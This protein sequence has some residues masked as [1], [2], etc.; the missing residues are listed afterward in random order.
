[1]QSN[2]LTSRLNPKN[3]GV[4][5]YSNA[6][7][8][9]SAYA[10]AKQAGEKEFMW[11]GKRFST[12]SDMTPEQQMKVYGIT[13]KQRITN[14]STYR[15]NLYDL[16]T[17]EGYNIPLLNVVDRA[18]GKNEKV[19]FSNEPNSAA[20]KEQ[21]ALRL[22]LGLPQ[23]ANTFKPSKYK[24]DAFELNNYLELLPN[25]MP[26]DEEINFYGKPLSQED[27]YKAKGT[28]K[29][30]KVAN[31][32]SG[33]TLKPLEDFV[34]GKHTVK[35]GKDE[36]GE[37][38]EY[39]DE[40]DFD[41][42]K[43]NLLKKK[44]PL[45]NKKLDIN[46]PLGDISDKFNKPYSIYGRK[47]YKDYGDG[48]KKTMYYSDKELSELDI[49]KKNFD[50]L[51]LQKELNNRGYDLPKSTISKNKFDGILGKETIDALT[52][53]QNKNSRSSQLSLQYQL[54]RRKRLR[55]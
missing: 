3:W 48:I 18:L 1:M 12:K 40:F 55:K 6:G 9:N 31:N 47:Y 11:N 7:N 44:I 10:S 23:K 41:T 33:N 17:V 53:W 43:L 27:F 35:K 46:I 13:D 32:Y 54:D 50:T 4:V 39:I 16:N 52:D 5:D 38:L 36:R 28:L 49:N 30:I 34:M 15:K 45:T 20:A 37:Y 21:D 24:K 42:Y 14:P 8:F 26:S 19:D 29:N 51:A 22:Y 25:I 2:N